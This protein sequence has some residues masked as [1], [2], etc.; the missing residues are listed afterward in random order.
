VRFPVLIQLAHLNWQILRTVLRAKA[1]GGPPPLGRELRI[2]PSRKTKDGTFLDELVGEG[3]LAPAG[4]PE[5]ASGSADEPVQFRTRYKLTEKGR[6]AAEYGEYD[7]PYT[8][9]DM[10]LTGTAAEIAEARAARKTPVT[11]NNPPQRRGKKKG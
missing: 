11:A 4:K 7:R 8:P 9:G 10:P 2:T 3:L 6:Q 5:K 1:A